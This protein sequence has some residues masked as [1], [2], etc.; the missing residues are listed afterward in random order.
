MPWRTARTAVGWP[1]WLRMRRTVLLL[2]ARTHE[3]I[4]R[5]V[6]HEQTV[7]KAAFSPDGRCLAT[8]SRDRTVR[9]WQ[10]GGGECR[11]LSGHTDEVFAVAFHPDGTRLAT[12]AH[13]GT[14]WLWDLARGKDVARLQG[15]TSFVWSLAFSPD[16]ATLASG[17]GDSTVRLWDTAPLKLR[18]QA[19]REAEALRPEAERLVAA[20]WRQKDDPA[21][22]VGAL[23]ADQALS[24]PLRHAALRRAAEADAAR[25][26][27]GPLGRP[28]LTDRR[29]DPCPSCNPWS[30]ISV[31]QRRPG[32]LGWDDLGQAGQSV[33]RPGRLGREAGVVVVRERH[34]RHPTGHLLDGFGAG[35]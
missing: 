19:R 17:S 31:E 23:R 30:R 12:A 9:L 1:P 32:P 21:G 24:E 13:D 28:A 6:G 4:A 18:Y 25:G 27:P 29:L 35:G 14:V 10:V 8:C 34:D 15:H 20:L 5:F 7:F 2:D 26:P 16:G 11:V 22:V 33:E 3:T